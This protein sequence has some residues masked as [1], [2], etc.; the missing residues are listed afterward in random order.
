[1]SMKKDMPGFRGP[2]CIDTHPQPRPNKLSCAIG[3]C[4]V[5]AKI[6]TSTA[7]GSAPTPLK[8]ANNSLTPLNLPLHFQLPPTNLGGFWKR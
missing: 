1:M 3:M 2:P 8:A 4:K 5:G 6:A 7:L